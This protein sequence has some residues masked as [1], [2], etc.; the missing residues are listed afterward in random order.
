MRNG[1]DLDSFIYSFYNTLTL[2]LSELD[3]R[4]YG[5][6]VLELIPSEFKKLPIPYTEINNNQFDNFTTNFENKLN[7]EQI[8]NQNDLSILYPTLG[9]NNEDLLKL[10]SIRNK[11]KKKRLRK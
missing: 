7:I 4:Y 10:S 6:G 9:I 8:L 2:L 5:G 3:G 11:L 1:Y